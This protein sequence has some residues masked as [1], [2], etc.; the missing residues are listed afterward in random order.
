VDAIATRILLPGVIFLPGQDA[1]DRPDD[2]I[3]PGSFIAGEENWVALA[4]VQRMIEADPPHC[5]TLFGP[6]GT[7]KT[8]LLEL[9]CRLWK[10]IWPGSTVVFWTAAE[11]GQAFAEAMAS[12]KPRQ[13]RRQWETAQFLI[14][15]DLQFLAEYPAGQEEFVAVLRAAE[16]GKLCVAVGSRLPPSYVDGLDPRIGAILQ[17]GLSAPLHYPGEE[18]RRALLR[19]AF[20][21]KAL[22]VTEAALQVFVEEITGSP[23]QILGFAMKLRQAIGRG[24]VDYPAA[25]AFLREHGPRP[26][27]TIDRVAKATARY[28]GIRLKDL[29]GPGRSRS[30][31]FARNVAM[32]LAQQL[33]GASLQQIGQYFGGRDHTTVGYGCRKMETLAQSDPAIRKAIMMIEQQVVPGET[34]TF[35]DPAEARMSSP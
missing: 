33:T 19:M 12:R 2:R 29:R 14:L 11:F 32:Y 7:G 17:G 25:R 13:F 35:S 10:E 16:R 27:T 8:Y 9:L 20:R 24:V 30:E 22:A 21:E 26:T 4:A 18:A 31:V 5:F 23:R 1:F 3:E 34:T 15:D 6:T 28:F